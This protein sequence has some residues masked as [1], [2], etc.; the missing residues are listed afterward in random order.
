MKTKNDN[1]PLNDDFEPIK[2]GSVSE[3]TKGDPIEAG[4]DGASDNSRE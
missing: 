3:E 1:R 2:L 4:E